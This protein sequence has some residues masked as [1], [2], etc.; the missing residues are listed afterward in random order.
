MVLGHLE[1][2][3][4]LK[5]GILKE[6]YAKEEDDKGLVGGLEV[7]NNL[8]ANVGRKEACM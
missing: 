8:V 4:G 2:R 7:W 5:E 3:H 1:S 6:D